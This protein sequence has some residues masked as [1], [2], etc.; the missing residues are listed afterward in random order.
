MQE[1]LS[2][3]QAGTENRKHRLFLAC[4][5]APEA[6]EF[7]HAWA[8]RE[9]PYRVL[10][11]ESLHATVSFVGEVDA[12]RRDHLARLV[13]RLQWSGFEVETGGLRWLGRGALALDLRAGKEDLRRLGLLIQGISAPTERQGGPKMLHA[14]IARA[15]DRQIAPRLSPPGKTFRLDRL[16]LFESHLEAVEARYEVVAESEHA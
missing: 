9:L 5:L 2:K 13:G 1:G 3:M 15:K 11:A 14:T 12:A 4:P 7:I 16:V 10:P 6:A 8:M